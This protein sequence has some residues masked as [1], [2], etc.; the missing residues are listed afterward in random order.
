MALTDLTPRSG[1]MTSSVHPS[2]GCVAPSGPVTVSRARPAAAPT[3]T[4][5]PAAAFGRANR[6]G[7]PCAGVRRAVGAGHGLQGPHGGGADGHDLPARASR[8]V[9]EPGRG[10]RYP[11]ELLVGRLVLLDAGDAGVQDQGRN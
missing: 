4:D 1:V 6:A 11:V 3:A 5:F 8:R 2:P 9:D 7:P 10:C